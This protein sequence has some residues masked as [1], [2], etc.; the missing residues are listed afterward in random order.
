MIHCTPVLGLSGDHFCKLPDSA[1]VLDFVVDYD[2]LILSLVIQ[3]PGNQKPLDWPNRR[4]VSVSSDFLYDTE[5]YLGSFSYGGIEY[6]V[7]VGRP[8]LGASAKS[9]LYDVRSTFDD[10]MR[11]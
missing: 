9:V 10:F 4:R 3:T 7:A 11:G 1:K 5:D 6:L 2:E 8:I